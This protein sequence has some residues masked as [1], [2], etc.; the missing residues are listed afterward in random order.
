MPTV[1]GF[2]HRPGAHCGS[3]ALRDLAESCAGV[4]LSEAMCFGLGAGLGFAYLAAPALS[5]SHGFCARAPYLEPHFFLHLGTPFSWRN[6][7][8]PWEELCQYIDAGTPILTLT[9]LYYLDYYTSSV[10]FGGHAVIAAG[11]LPAIDTG[12]SPAPAGSPGRGAAGSVLLA[13]TAWPD[14]QEVPYAHFR[15]AMHSLAPPFPVDG[16]WTPVPRSTIP[17]GVLPRAVRSAL[18]TCARSYLQAPPPPELAR[19]GVQH[20]G[21]SGLRAMAATLPSWADAPDFAWCCRY[22][23]QMIEKR[24]TGGSAF[25]R[26]YAAFLREARTLEPAIPLRAI[27]ELEM[28][29]ALWSEAATVFRELAIGSDPAGGQPGLPAEGCTP[30]GLPPDEPTAGPPAQPAVAAALRRVADILLEVASREEEALTLV[31]P[32]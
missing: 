2:V 11:Y 19:L 8:L 14:L 23:Y 13:D 32:I 10:H 20:Y 31:A 18:A 7:P 15:R 3:T 1:T 17:E 24:G 4:V 16:Q 28:A 21:I 12:T 6:A 5:P 29:A 30:E 27:T 26:M 22:A 25:R 9:D